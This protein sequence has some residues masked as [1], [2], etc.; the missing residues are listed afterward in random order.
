MNLKIREIGAMKHI[1]SLLAGLTLVILL[2]GVNAQADASWDTVLKLFN[3]ADLYKPTD[4]PGTG[5]G[6]YGWLKC[7]NSNFYSQPVTLDGNGLIPECQPDTLYSWGFRGKLQEFKSLMTANRRWDQAFSQMLFAHINPIATFAYGDVALRMKLKPGTKFLYYGADQ[8]QFNQYCSQLLNADTISNTVIVRA[9]SHQGVTGV[10]YILCS[11]EP[12]ESWSYD[13]K[14]HYD[15]IVA[16]QLWNNNVS[17]TQ[18]WVP[19]AK[20]GYSAEYFDC[21]LDN[22]DW[23]QAHLLKNLS[24]M[25]S[26]AE[27][28]QGQI[29]FAEGVPHSPSRH[30]STN[31]PI[32]WNSETFNG[33]RPAVHVEPVQN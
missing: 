10:D 24:V 12:V 22:E 6:Y 7:F 32:Y 23:S 1:K 18:G 29:L 28:G 9:W 2:S 17:T 25:Q 13:T 8:L 31:R 30:F 3:T 4:T 27:E 20:A 21:G 16:S 26:K 14:K 5:G 11:T 33:E 19:Y 15:E